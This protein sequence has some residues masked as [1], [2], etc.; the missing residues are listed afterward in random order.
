MQTGKNWKEHDISVLVKKDGVVYN[1]DHSLKDF[2]E[3][4]GAELRAIENSWKKQMSFLWITKTNVF[5][6]NG[7]LLLVSIR[8]ILISVHG[9]ELLIEAKKV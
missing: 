6:K 5:L 1:V 7:L 4:F 2:L 3:K 8:S 9:R